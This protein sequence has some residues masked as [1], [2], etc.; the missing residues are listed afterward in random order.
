[1]RA[2]WQ[3]IDERL[4]PVALLE[5]L[6]ESRLPSPDAGVESGMDAADH[7]RQVR[8]EGQPDRLAG[9]RRQTLRDLR[10]VP[11]SGDAI[12]LEIVGGFREEGSNLGLAAGAGDAGLG[13]GNQVVDVDQAGSTSGMKPSCTA[14]G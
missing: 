4:A 2:G 12:G 1:M 7:G 13:V 11:V 6:P 8:Y 10:Q 3:D 5:Q 14:V 9:H